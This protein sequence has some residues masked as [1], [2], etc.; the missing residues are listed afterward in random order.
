MSALAG[1]LVVEV[2]AVEVVC[3]VVSPRRISVVSVAPLVF[4][5]AARSS[6]MTTDVLYPMLSRLL[7]RVHITRLGVAVACVNACI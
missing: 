5:A 2:G 3:P 6:G 4:H 1:A 7:P